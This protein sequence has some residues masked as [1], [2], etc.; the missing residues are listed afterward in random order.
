MEIVDTGVGMSEETLSRIFRPFER[1]TSATNADGFGLGLPIT[2]G[3]VNLL[4][5]TIEVTSLIN[6]GSTFRVTLPMPETDEP[7]E[8]ENMSRRIPHTCI[9]MY[10]LLMTTV[11][12]KL[13]LKK[14]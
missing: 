6:C 1:H 13:S 3:L 9:T 7:L 5:G 11:C 4:D 14:C 12:C 2:Q 10:L 8:S